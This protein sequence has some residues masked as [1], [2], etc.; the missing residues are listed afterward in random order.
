[1]V[2]ARFKQILLFIL[3]AAELSHL[4]EGNPI[5]IGKSIRLKMSRHIFYFHDKKT[6]TGK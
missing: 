3:C 2:L 4:S 5:E 1:M 6:S